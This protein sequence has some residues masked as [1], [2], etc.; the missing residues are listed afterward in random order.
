VMV[1]ALENRKVWGRFKECADAVPMS[2]LSD[3]TPGT[4]DQTIH[5]EK[6]FGRIGLG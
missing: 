1:V 3:L 6:D 4:S 5:R 2:D